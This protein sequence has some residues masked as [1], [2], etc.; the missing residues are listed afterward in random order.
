MFEENDVIATSYGNTYCLYTVFN[1]IDC[2]ERSL[3]VILKQLWSNFHRTQ[4][5]ELHVFPQEI[6]CNQKPVTRILESWI[7]TPE[8]GNR[9]PASRI[10]NPGD[11]T[12]ENGDV[13]EKCNDGGHGGVAPGGQ[14]S[15]GVACRIFQNL[16]LTV[17]AVPGLSVCKVSLF[18]TT[19]L[20]FETCQVLVRSTHVLT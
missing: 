9:N 17:W 11:L 12:Q 16:N 7:R 8:S 2:I 15:E 6:I 18:H 19:I 4:V 10:L 20:Q 14:G 13:W 3:S 5:Y 1:E